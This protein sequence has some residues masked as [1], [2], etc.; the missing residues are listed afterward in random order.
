[1]H[2][3]P[4]E[5][6]RLQY[7]YLND[8]PIFYKSKTQN[9]ATLSLSEAKLIAAAEC[10]KTMLFV[11]QILAS[12]GLSIEKPMI[13]EIDC[14]G[15]VDLNNNG[16]MGRRTFHIFVKKFLIWDL[17]E[18]GEFSIMWLPSAQNTRDLYTKNLDGPMFEKHNG[19]YV[20]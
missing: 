7:I 1:M 8:A 5:Y 6:H 10:A 16:T 13:L 4:E 20:F 17:K 9:S 2:G 12:I 3:R 15:T 19:T 18:S 14:K 11:R